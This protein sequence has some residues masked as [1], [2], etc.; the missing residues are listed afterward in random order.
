MALPRSEARRGRAALLYRLPASIPPIADASSGSG[1]RGT[2]PAAEGGATHAPLAADLDSAGERTCPCQ[3]VDRALPNAKQARHLRY[4]QK[5]GRHG[6]PPPAKGRQGSVRL[7][8]RARANR[9]S[10]CRD[11]PRA[12]SHP[13]PDHPLPAPDGRRDGRPPGDGDGRARGY[14][15]GALIPAADGL[16][17][18]TLYRHRFGGLV[19]A[20]RLTG[21]ASRLLDNATVLKYV[22]PK[23][24]DLLAKL[25]SVAEGTD[26]RT[27]GAEATTAPGRSPEP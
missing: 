15:Q 18:S 3:R 24:R 9:A 17:S 20:N 7:P 1:N 2:R 27:D 22:S 5:R 23:Y 12:R 13:S 10:S 25:E 6:L 8:V 4:R 14:L 19:E 11:A 21:Y 26:L 16:P